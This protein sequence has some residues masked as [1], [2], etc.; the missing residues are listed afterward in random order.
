M[1]QSDRICYR[2]AAY[3]TEYGICCR[4]IAYVTERLHM[5]QSSGLCCRVAAYVTGWPNI[6]NVAACVTG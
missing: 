6:Y 1:L 4:M 3:V 5:L 2:A